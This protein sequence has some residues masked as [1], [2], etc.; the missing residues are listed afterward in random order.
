M[1]HYLKSI[2]DSIASGL[3]YI[4]SI[5]LLYRETRESDLRNND[6]LNHGDGVGGANG[7]TAQMDNTVSR[8]PKARGAIVKSQEGAGL[9]RHRKGAGAIGG[10]DP[11]G[12][13]RLDGG[14]GETGSI[15]TGGGQSGGGNGEGA[16]ICS[17]R[18]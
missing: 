16:S 4:R 13:H 14:G 11:I 2:R 8:C 12:E 9:A 10:K 15:A 3:R 6:L 7:I 18:A 1:Q 5:N 17:P